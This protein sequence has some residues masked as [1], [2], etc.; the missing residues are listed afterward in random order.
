M[1]F[2]FSRDKYFAYI[3]SLII[4]MDILVIS[5]FPFLR[6]IFGFL[7]LS[8]IPGFLIL[9][10]LKLN[11]IGFTERFVLSIGLSV[12]FLMFFGIILNNISLKFGYVT[13]LSPMFLLTVFSIIF[14][15]LL[16][17]G[18]TVNEESVNFSLNLTLNPLEKKFLII[19]I[20]LPTLSLF[21]IYVM[22]TTNSNVL[23]MFLFLLVPSYVVFVSI[24]KEAFPVKLYP[25]VIF[26]ISIS[27]LLL[28][29]LRSN[30][31]I[32]VDIHLEYCMF[33]KVLS[34][35]HW[36]NFKESTLDSCLSI[37]LLPTIYK[38]FLNLDPIFLFKLLY[39]LI[40][41]VSPLVVYIISNKYF[42]ESYSFL[43]SCFY[44][45]Q[46]NFLL[47]EYNAR[48]N[49]A[50]LFF[51]LSMM[52]LFNERI[53]S[54]SKK[55]LLLTFM[56]SC[57]FSH[58]STTYIFFFILIGSFILNNLF[59]LKYAS[60]YNVNSI[61]SLTTISLFFI[62]IFFWYGQITD[63][64]FNSAIHFLEKSV[65][66]LH[67]LFIEESRQTD[68]Q[69]MFGKDIT[70]KGIPHKIHFIVTWLSFLFIGV[71]TLST[72]LNFNEFK[73]LKVKIKNISC[74]N[75]VFDTE[76]FTISISC[77]GLL[78]AIVVIPIVSVGYS[79]ER[80]YALTITILSTFFV[81][82]GFILAKYL[83]I[84]SRL[85]IL[86][87]L[88]PYFLSVSG[89]TYQVFGFPNNIILNSDG[90]QYDSLYVH[91]QDKYGT[92]WLKLHSDNET[93]V[94][95][96]YYSKYQLISQAGF[97][98]RSINSDRLPFHKKLYGQ[99]IYLRYY[100]C[101]DKKLYGYDKNLK[102]SGEFDL[103]DYDSTFRRECLIYSNGGSKIYA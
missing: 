61:V 56:I 86:L 9:R 10:I 80:L 33:Q 62:L 78:F 11:E 47:T 35:L 1:E 82:G 68:L 98:I 70:Q 83:N 79:L 12:F 26:L 19:P 42:E 36:A 28:L 102:L 31:I 63:I 30:N 58:Y 38:S 59:F 3:F 101:I 96:D 94:E 57:L 51:G 91:D 20:I 76:F 52:V 16:I 37:S 4:F 17:L 6:Q 2:Q 53:N 15:V 41:S 81:V 25:I 95:A 90:N 49:I 27:L 21:G 50:I 72:L 85:L 60:K 74:L 46:S 55:V 92:I 43:A 67:E 45:F 5:D 22:N 34:E 23:L 48:T 66:S 64:A 89:F 87:V 93:L 88:I 24:S 65:S 8:F 13:P 69:A 84:P 40:Y 77:L 32:G 100:N 54:V 39:S 71:G 73:F 99:Y 44:M 7:F 18:Y 75:K 14:I 97:P 103:S 29:P